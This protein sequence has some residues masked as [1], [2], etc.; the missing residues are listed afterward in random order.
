[1]FNLTEGHRVQRDEEDTP[2]EFL[3]GYD[4]K[5]TFLGPYEA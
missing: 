1:M 4:F 5:E 2:E 3:G